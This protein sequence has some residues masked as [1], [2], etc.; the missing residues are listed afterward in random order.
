M[1]RCS[2]SRPPP[3]TTITVKAADAS[4]AFTTQTFTIA[5]T[6]VA[7]T[8]PVD[9]NN[10]A[11][12]VSEGAANGDLVGITATSSDV[13]GG[14]VTFSLSDDAGGRFAIDA[15]TG[16]VT[17]ANASLLDFETTTSHDITVKAADA[18]GAF[19]TQTS[20]LPSPTWRRPSLSTATMPPTRF[21]KRRQRRPGRHH[22]DSSDVNG[23]TVTFSLSDDAGGRFAIDASTGVVTVAN[24]SLLDFETTTSHDI[25]VKAADASGAFTTQT[26][27]IAVTDV[28]PTQPVDGNNAANTV[29]EGAANGD[30]VGITA[31]SSDV[32]GGTVTFSLSDDAGGRFAIDASTGVVTVANASLLD[33]ETTT[34]HDITV[35]AADAS[36]AFTTQTFTIAVTDVAPTQPV[37]GNNAAN[38]VSEGAA[39]GDLVGITATSSDVN[40]GTVTFS[41]SDD[42]GGRFAID[43]STGVVTVANASLLDFETT[44]SHDI[45][46]KAA[47]AS[48][49]FTTQ[50]FTIAVT[51]VA[52]TQP[53]DGNNA[54]NTVSEGAANGDL[55]GITATSSDVNGGT[56]TFSLSDDAGGRFAIDASTGVVTVANASLLDFETTTSHDITVKAADASG[57]FTTQTF[58]IAVTDVAP[59]QPVDG[60]NAANTVSEGAANGDLVGITATS[61]DVNGGTVTFSLS[62]DAGGRFA[63]DASTGVVTVANASLLD[64]ETTTSHDITVKAADASGAFTTQTFTIAVTDVA[65][66]QP[67]DGNNAANTVSEGAA[68]GDLV[69]ITATSSDVNGGTVTFSLSDDAGGRFAIDAST[70]VVTVAN[71][72]LL[73]FETTTSHDITVKAADASGAF[74]TQT[75]TIAV[76]DVAPTQPVDGNNAANT[77]SE[78]AANGDLVGITATSSDVNGGTVTFSLSDDAGGR[79]AIDAST[80]VVTV[81]NASLLDFETTTSHDITVKAADASGAFTTQT[82]TI[83]VTDV[84]PTQPVDGNNA[85][86]T[87]SEGA[88]NGD[89]VGITATSSDVNGGTV[90]FSLSDDAGG[91]F[92]ID[93]STGV[94]TVANA[95]L[96]D[97]ETTTSHDITVKAADAS[98]AF[99]TQTFTIAVTD[100]APTQPVDG[101]NA[102][103]TVSEGAANGDLVGITATSSD[104]NG[105]TVT[106]SLSDDA[107]GRFAIDASTGVVTVANASL[108][109]FETTTSHDITVKAAD[110]S[111]AFT[112][113]T[114]TIAVTDV[115]PTQPVD[116]NNAA[117]TVSEG[118][119]NG[120]LVGI[121]ATS[122]D[123]NG[124][125]VT[126]S[127][128]DDAGGRFAIDASTGVVT[129]ANASLLDFETTT[130][131]D[132]TVKAADASGAFTTQTFTIAV[133]DVAPTQ[134]VDGNNAANT[135]SEGAANGDLV[136]ITAT[137]SDVNGGTVTFSLSDD[138]GGRFAIDASTGVV[139]VA[140]AS[141]LDFETTTS[142][143]ITV[144]AADA[145]GAFT[146]QT[147]TIAVTDVAPTQPVDGNNA[148]NTVS[149]G[150]ANGDLVGI[151]ATSSDVNG[152]TVTFSLSDDAGGR[153]AIDASTGVVTVANASLLDFE[154]TTSHD[155]TV[156]AADASGAFTTQTFTIAVTDVAPTQPVDGNNAANTVS[157]GAANG[158][159]VG[160][161]ATSSDVNGGTVTFSLSDDAG[162]RF[163]ID[164]STGVVTVANASLLDF[165]TTTSHDIT[166]KAADASGA[167]TTQTFTIAVTDVAPTQPVDGNNAANTVSEGAA[168]GDLVGITATS[169]D[170]NGG[171]VTFSLSDD[172][173]GRF[174]IDASTG[175]VTVAN[176]SL[177]DFETTT[178]HD[179]TVK[180]ADA[181]GAF[182]TQTFTIAVTDVAPT[183]PVDGNNAA[184]TVSEGAANGDLVGITAT[185]SDVNGGTVTFSLSD[186]AGGRFAI[187]ASTGVV[188]VANASLLDFETTTSHD[189]TVKAAD[190]SGAFTTQTFTIAVT[191]VAPTQPVDGNNAANTVSEGAANGDLVGITATSSDVNGGTVTFSLSDDAGGRFAIDASTGVV[192]VANAS[193]LDFETT[194]S[195]D[196]T[197]KAADASGAFTTQT[198][199]IAVT[200]VAPTQPVDGNNAANTVSE[201]AANGDLVG[202]TATSSDVNGGT[203]T[204]SLS[205]DAGGRFAI[206][207]STGV[208]TVANASLLDFETTTSHDITVKAADASG[209][210]TTQTFTIA[211]TDVAPTQP[212]DGNN[213]ANTVSEGAANGDL[214][215]ITATSSDVNGGTVTFSLS[216]DAGGR[217]AIDA[218]TGVVTVANAS[219]L[220]FETTTSHDITVKAAD[221]SGAFT[222]QTFTI[223]VTDV[224]PTQPV[225]G[226]NAANTVSEGAANGD[227]VGITATSSDVNGGTVTFSL[228]DD[229]GGRFAIDAS[230]GV[231]TVAN[232]SLLDFE[233]TTSHD[234]TVKAADASGAFTTQTF[235]I[236]VTDVAPT[237]PVDGNNAANTVSEGAA[238]GDL[239]GITATSS[240]V[241]GGTVTFS[242]SDDAGGRFAIDASTG[243]VTVANASLLDFETTTSHDITVKAA[244]AS[245]AFTTQTFTI[246]VTDVAPTQPVDGNN[247]ANTVSEGAAN[248]DLVGI[249]ATSS[250]VNGGTVTFSLS[251]DA[252]GRFAIDA[253]TGVVTVANASLLDFETTTSHDIT[254]KAADASGAF[255]TQTFTI[256]VT[257]V[258][259][260]QPVDGN[261]AANTVSEGAANGDLV[262]ITATSSDVNGGTVTFSL[263][264]DAG[265]RFAIDA[266]TGVVTVA[267]ASLLDFETTTSHDITVKAADA[268]GAFTTQTFTIAVTDVAPTQPVDG[269]NAANTVS[270]GAANGDLVGITATSSD[271]NGG[272]VTFSLSDD[273]G[274]RFAID[275]STGVVTVA[276]ASL[277]DFETTTSH[278]ITVKA[279]DASGAFTTQTFTIAVTDV[280]PTQPVDGNNAANTVSEGAANGDLVGITATS[281]DVNGGTVTFSLSDDAGGRFAIDASTGVVTVAN[282]S[283]LDFETT[284]SHD[285]TV[286]AADASGAFTTQT[287][288]IAVTDVAPT[289]PVD[290]NNAANT[291]SEGAANGDLVG[292][293]ATSSDVNGGTVTFSLSDDAGGRFAIDASTGVVTVANA[294]LLDFESAAGHAYTVTAQAS[295]G[296]L[297][298]SQT[299]TINVTDVAPST[300]VDSN[301]ASNTV[302][303]GAANGSTVGVT[304][305]S[306]DV[307]GPAVTYSLTGDTSGGGF[308]INAATGVITVA[309]ASKLDYESA[310]GHAYTVTAQASDGTLSSSQTFTIG[311]PTW[312]PRPRS[313]ATRQPTPLPKVRPT[314]QPS[315]LP[316]RRA[317]STDRP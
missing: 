205:D 106:F 138:A 259:P 66:T 99:T 276:N 204:F 54:A 144:K 31:T 134:P 84:A 209:A 129:V 207:A 248:G 176:A 98:G 51:D 141:L 21:R 308:T 215:G 56:V 11:N 120:D 7:P 6:D 303:E 230:T 304:V 294:S 37:D 196:I 172:A 314:A 124:G 136:G 96:L 208:V 5:V 169:S 64:F 273:A 164:A 224:A 14:T 63:I 49:A 250:D 148:A 13:N 229:A 118:A 26:F 198:F 152:G 100:V 121:T 237:Q 179:I 285:I 260:T 126:F 306:S 48:G 167:F 123:V 242:L 145:S 171:T 149:E 163:A 79:F 181:S 131:H 302:A 194:T 190:A 23:G 72:S 53:V 213:A 73:D 156:K 139:T 3:A 4:G 290:G 218:S 200:D 293:T 277:L 158:D 238:N 125:T 147:F 10:A 68:N 309:D 101:N 132:I 307:N 143:D 197:V 128:S 8:Q 291:V 86:N 235:T 150:A 155:I 183:Q 289:Q 153:F 203:V 50:T 240:D 89:L 81:A 157:E 211:V 91:R 9:G 265:G 257:D 191:D 227:L 82:F 241:N 255:T 251:D 267:N 74:T 184:N 288:T 185:S 130:S 108:L 28:A 58:T 274:G 104:V 234:I 266:S 111:G 300:P 142:H 253:S 270:E 305:S 109:D 278:D 40:G 232:A 269:N 39:N 256:A 62:D 226:N 47:D 146:T 140:N 2:T 112:T 32:N 1:P 272:T 19:T 44:T 239:V 170:V 80:G 311:S 301:A 166:V 222:T 279:A 117:N 160:I 223:A 93:A 69:G 246:A 286:K 262:G 55:V 228:S 115:A 105:G 199:T 24:A 17:V 264:D 195:H 292:I 52:P 177:L 116:G 107:G 41:L 36:G 137:S 165:E 122:S 103:N 42:A 281:S 282:A 193:L 70:G 173:G 297:S 316:C 174:A 57:A 243:V 97:F 33:F 151:T 34:S 310:A 296:T 217:F 313:T 221:A 77:V 29:S 71:A 133:T 233:T 76:T 247:A 95:S 219:L 284:T 187:D 261:N 216:D 154:T 90:T 22:R 283:L 231:V 189:I 236:A 87:V 168:N 161:T 312:R 113:Q 245:G 244:D 287:F 295:D 188:T 178:S 249:T 212:V 180:A 299:F 61:S 83:A 114:F 210:F 20:P 12:T 43:A 38:T 186:D 201:G 15:S 202:I 102:A 159:L 127:L 225:D 192:T 206:D 92:A 119:A 254:V 298:S 46:V 65:P 16:V 135:V 315:A 85:A 78:G 258:A 162:G 263:S 110:A 220:D 88:A 175:V 275:A 67:V 252:G 214:V 30:L 25:T 271:V 27:T 280:A 94:V 182:T 317:T 35:K 18:S 268:S 75:F 60:N 45:T 59:T